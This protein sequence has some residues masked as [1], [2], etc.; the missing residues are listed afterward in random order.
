[1]AWPEL[2]GQLRR[3][4]DGELLEG[5]CCRLAKAL[6]G[7][8]QRGAL[9]GSEAREWLRTARVLRSA[10]REGLSQALLRAVVALSRDPG[11]AAAAM[12]DRF[13][14]GDLVGASQRTRV[15][16]LVHCAGLLD[17][18]T[19]VL[20]VLGVHGGTRVETQWAGDSHRG[21]SGAASGALMRRARRWEVA[22]QG[23]ERS[24]NPTAHRSPS[25]AAQGGSSALPSGDSER[26]AGTT[27]SMP[28]NTACRLKNTTNEP[29]NTTQG[30]ASDASSAALA[31][32]RA[33][34]SNHHDHDV[35]PWL[36]SA[37]RTRLQLERALRDA[38]T[39]SSKN[40]SRH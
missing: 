23:S 13:E 17:Q 30:M 28:G 12:L 11:E 16:W 25:A 37:L 39:C 40:G 2:R 27:A 32:L 34:T 33:A 5:L 19:R 14:R 10:G 38:C 8:L 3:A 15:E 18:R 26:Q 4:G 29:R 9:D 20:R 21:S 31:V 35:Q 24:V 36:A 7:G 6:E 22:P 1:M